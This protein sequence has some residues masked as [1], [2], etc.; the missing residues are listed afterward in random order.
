MFIVKLTMIVEYKV[1]WPVL[2]YGPLE[3]WHDVAC[4][5]GFDTM[6][7]NEARH[8]TDKHYDILELVLGMEWTHGIH[9]D[10]IKR[11]FS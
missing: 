3:D 2:K 5:E 9:T 6:K 1:R 11:N 10:I 8:V 7:L 4:F